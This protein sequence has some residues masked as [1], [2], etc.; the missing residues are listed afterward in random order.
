MFVTVG[1]T[2]LVMPGLGEQFYV[3]DDNEDNRGVTKTV[4]FRVTKG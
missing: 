1:Q 3:S 2:P 4:G